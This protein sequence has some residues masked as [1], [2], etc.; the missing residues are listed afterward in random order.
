MQVYSQVSNLCMM[1]RGPPNQFIGATPPVRYS[2]STPKKY[3]IYFNNQ[4]HVKETMI[5]A[6]LKTRCK[7][8]TINLGFTEYTI[9]DIV[10]PQAPT[11]HGTTGKRITLPG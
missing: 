2:I 8:N 4:N 10:Y 7:H 3:N 1:H 11:S 6:K 9:Y 5:Q